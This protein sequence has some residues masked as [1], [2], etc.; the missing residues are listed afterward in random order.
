MPIDSEVQEELDSINSNLNTLTDSLNTLTDNLNTLTI[1]FNELLN[2][3]NVFEST[4]TYKPGETAPQWED[5]NGNKLYDEDGNFI[6]IASSVSVD[7]TFDANT[8]GVL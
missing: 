3:F 1:D 8:F 7:N 5:S 2:R 4:F 6:Y